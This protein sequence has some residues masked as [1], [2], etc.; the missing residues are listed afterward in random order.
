VLALG[1]FNGNYLPDVLT[2]DGIR[3]EWTTHSRMQEARA[4]AAA[5]ACKSAVVVAGGCGGGYRLLPGSLLLKTADRIEL[6]DDASALCSA[7][8]FTAQANSP[9]RHCHSTLS[10]T[11]IDCHPSGT[12]TVILRAPLPFSVNMTAPPRAR[13][14]AKAWLALPPMTTKRYGCR[15]V[16]VEH[17]TLPPAQQD[18]GRPEAVSGAQE[19]SSCVRNTQ[20]LVVRNRP[21]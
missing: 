9:G 1:G 11:V 3:R 18:P 2:Y 7:E 8:I 10:M 19:T 20:E 14:Q 5:A 15:M 17:G 21:R 12:H 4:G 16:L 6:V 13:L